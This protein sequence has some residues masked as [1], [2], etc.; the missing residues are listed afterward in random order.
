MAVRGENQGTCQVI[1]WV[2]VL[3]EIAGVVWGEDKI[4]RERSMSRWGTDVVDVDGVV[5]RSAGDRC[6]QRILCF[7]H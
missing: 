5:A 3:G 2:Q 7:L 1:V 4:P 6:V